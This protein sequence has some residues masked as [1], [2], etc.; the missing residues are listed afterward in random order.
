MTHLRR[1]RIASE[2]VDDDVL[3]RLR[4][5]WHD[6]RRVN[7]DPPRH[8]RTRDEAPLLN[9]RVSTRRVRVM[10]Q[11]LMPGTRLKLS[12]RH[13]RT[14]SRRSDVRLC[15]VPCCPKRVVSAYRPGRASAYHP[16]HHPD[17]LH[18]VSSG[19]PISRFS[20]STWFYLSNHPE[21]ARPAGEGAL[22]A[23]SAGL[24]NLHTDILPLEE[25]PRHTDGSK[26]DR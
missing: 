23:V 9:D 11:E 3:D 22:K 26:P 2:A 6:V 1:R 17:T 12:Q 19:S 21:S 15:A 13:G 4:P 25:A 7:P 10:E 5:R 14:V 18:D 20:A 24:V 16:R 8:P